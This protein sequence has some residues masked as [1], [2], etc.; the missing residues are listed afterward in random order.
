MALKIH[1]AGHVQ[2]YAHLAVVAAHL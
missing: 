1:A 2:N